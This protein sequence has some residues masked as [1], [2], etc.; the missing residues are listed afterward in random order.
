LTFWQKVDKPITK[1][2]VRTIV[3]SY[4]V[5]LNGL[6]AREFILGGR[7]ALLETE[8]PITDLMDGI[9]RFHIYVTPPPPAEQIVGILEF[10]PQYLV[11]LFKAVA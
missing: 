9:L 11:Q 3:N 10:D 8:N 5:R 7:V 6:A 4:N 1:R 2:L